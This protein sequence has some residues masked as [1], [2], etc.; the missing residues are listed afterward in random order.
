MYG[1]LTRTVAIMMEA[2]E[3]DGTG[4]RGILLWNKTACW[5]NMS[6][7]VRWPHIVTTP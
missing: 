4:E 6:C 2:L 1:M 5:N 3:F 7:K